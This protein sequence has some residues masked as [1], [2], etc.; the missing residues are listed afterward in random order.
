MDRHFPGI[1]L[2]AGFSALA[3]SV[4]LF[5][6]QPTWSALGIPVGHIPFVDM[7]TVQW[8]PQS[9]DAGVDPQKKVLRDFSGRAMNYPMIWERLSR[10]LSLENEVVFLCFELALVFFYFLACFTIVRS[11]Q[12]LFPAILVFS[13]AG[14]LLLERGNND[15]LVF[16]LI[17]A[18]G[19]LAQGPRMA[20]LIL[21]LGA[22]KIYPLFAGVALLK[23][24]RVSLLF[25]LFSAGLVWSL[26]DALLKIRLATP[27]SIVW[28]YGVP[29]L[30]AFFSATY[31]EALSRALVA[32][33]HLVVAL[34]VFLLVP[35]PRFNTHR[36]SGVF[37]S[38]FLFGSGVYLFT[39]LL[40][41]N[42]DYR[43]VFLVLCV[44]RLSQLSNNFLRRL[45]FL[46][47][48]LAFNYGVLA[49]GPGNL[50]ATINIL[51]KSV[52]FVFLGHLVTTDALN[53]IRAYWK[54][55]GALVSPLGNLL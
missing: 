17:T 46:L 33:C 2:F 6:W 5:G 34:L 39:F 9:V 28:A 41:S 48:L 53:T 47:L 32:F 45:I 44:P 55:S 38:W 43:L 49:G 24:R 14:L 52:L 12:I 31:G 26:K 36:F 37:R 30:A 22:L 29:S 18:G 8:A 23:N 16:S 27:T 25:L 1:I 42:F 35:T 7:R 54:K 51:S 20:S 19:F 3:L 13:G 40:S 4:F 11:S 21:F 10:Y 50:G 15:L